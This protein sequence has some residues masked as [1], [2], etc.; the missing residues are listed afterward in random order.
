M[1]NRNSFHAKTVHSK[2]TQCKGYKT[3]TKREKNELVVTNCKPSHGHN[4]HS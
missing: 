2:H 4:M 1:Q 3:Y